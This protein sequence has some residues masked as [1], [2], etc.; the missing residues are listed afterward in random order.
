MI[1][2]LVAACG[3][4]EQIVEEIRSIKT[5]TV[6]EAEAGQLR[7]FSG[8]VRAVDRSALSFEVPGNV[9]IVNVDIGARVKKDQ[10]LA[11]L[12]N[13][14]YELEVAK[15]EAELVTARAK[16]TKQR[17][18]YEREKTIF[19]QGA[20][21]ER[22]L[23]QAEFSLKE[24]EA[25][26]D[27]VVSKLN[28]AKRDLR[29]TV[30]YAPYDGS[31]GVREVEPFVDVR[32]GQKIFEIDAQGEQE[33]EVGIPETVVQFLTV[34]MSTVV[35]FPTLPGKTVEGRVT[36]VG[37]LAGRGNAF[38]IKVRLLDPPPQVRSGMTAE[39]TFELKDERLGAGFPIPGHALVPTI[40]ANRGFVFVYQADTSMVK[41][42]PVQ[43]FGVKDNMVIISEGIAPGDIVAVAGVSFL[44]D[45]M[46]VKLMAKAE[47]PKPETLAV[48]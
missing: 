37:T 48:E 15:A 24:A 23:D 40:E 10:V 28:L 7:R 2:S 35:S 42:T 29:K 4:E 22:R 20:G 47:K 21:S 9:L 18:D 44:S 14:P 34:D 31:I 17:A 32:R 45:G 5:V 1:V 12:D 11:E 43:F 3:E 41:K 27:F 38:P 16:V 19:D 25:S 46:K 8:I 13:E 26:V 39:V 6:G 36:E 30:L 33:V